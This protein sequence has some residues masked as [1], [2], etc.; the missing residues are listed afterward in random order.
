MGK[1]PEPHRG[2]HRQVMARAGLAEEDLAVADQHTASLFV[3]PPRGAAPVC[4]ARESM[5]LGHHSPDL[6]GQWHAPLAEDVRERAVVPEQVVPPSVESRPER[7][8][9]RTIVG[10]DGAGVVELVRGRDGERPSS[11]VVRRWSRYRSFRTGQGSFSAR[12]LVSLSP[13][14]LTMAAAR[15]PKRDLMSASRSFPPWSSTAS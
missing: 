13:H 5:E 8:A 2:P 15:S 4:R 6:L 11:G 3:T 9:K 10:Q 14:D 7:L 12:L 1:A